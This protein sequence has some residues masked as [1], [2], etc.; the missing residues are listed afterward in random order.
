MLTM[1]IF[2]LAFTFVAFRPEAFALTKNQPLHSQIF[3]MSPR[4]GVIAPFTVEVDLG[5][6][7]LRKTF[8]PLM[9]ESTLIECRYAI[10]FLIDIE[11]TQDGIVVTKDESGGTEEVGDRL[12]A[13]TYYTID[14]DGGGGPVGMFSS[15][16]GGSVKWRRR[17]FDASSVPFETALQ[18][19][20]T[21]E[22]S[23]TSEVLMYFERKITGPSE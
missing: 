11:Q 17:L 19:L 16:G 12:R 22:P 13:F 3:R 8:E 23:R 9:K 7:T 6:T 14:N 21:N 2:T 10:P 4:P 20:V 18:A 1:M 15:F 5:E